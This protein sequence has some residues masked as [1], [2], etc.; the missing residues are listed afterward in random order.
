MFKERNNRLG[1][2]RI[3]VFASL[4]GIDANRFSR[5][6]Y[7]AAFQ[8]HHPA[9]AKS[10]RRH[11][12]QQEPMLQIRFGIDYFLISAFERTTGRRLS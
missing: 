9:H 11:H 2:Y 6:I 12:R 4:A 5:R 7:V 10:R 8:A 1:Q 3:T